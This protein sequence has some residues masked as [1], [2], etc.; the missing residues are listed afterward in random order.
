MFIQLPKE[1][2]YTYYGNIQ[3][4]AIEGCYVLCRSSVDEHWTTINQ[5]NLERISIS[6][7][8][9][10][11]ASRVDSLTSDP[12]KGTYLNYPLDK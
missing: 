3:V 10:L 8:L 7:G 12:N 11:P 1:G 6:F 5:D 4:E 2:C 9:M